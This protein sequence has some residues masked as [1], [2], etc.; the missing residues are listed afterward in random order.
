MKTVRML[1]NK[2]AEIIDMPE[3][4]P[5][6]DLVVVKI[7]SSVICGTEHNAYFGSAPLPID[8]GAGHEAAGIVWKTDKAGRVKEGDR[9]SIY[10]TIFEN[11]HRCPACQEGKWLHCL[12]PKP[13]RSVMGTHC[14]YML[15][16]ETIC[17]PI[18][19]ELSFDTGAMIDDCIGTPYRAIRRLGVNAGDIV[20]ITGA[21]PIGAAAAVISK[22]LNAKVII[23]DVN[24]YRLEQALKNGVDHI[25]NPTKNDVLAKVREIT[26]NRGADVA[27]E[28][29]GMEAAQIQCLDA[30]GVGG[31][32][33][34]LGI[35]AEIIPVKM[36]QH[37]ILKEL[38]LIGSWASTPPEHFKIVN[39][40]QRGMPADKL[41]THRYGID[42]APT[43][44]R[45]FFDGE[46][47]KV[48]INPWKV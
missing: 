32:V 46:A 9:V 25:F 5:R 6:D 43:A 31:K 8:G 29:S 33:A 16:P 10:P 7:M 36:M 4:E 39:L 28:C 38:T 41:I 15:V 24:D 3:P 19:D 47:V 11:C 42:D 45:K 13:K 1:G 23:V 44:L 21:G 40:I 30:T 27:V 20:L 37:F 17:L 34:F 22:F 35:K 2:Q 48:A 26:G 18:P 12:H 14:Q